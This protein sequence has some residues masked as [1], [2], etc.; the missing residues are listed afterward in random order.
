MSRGQ[1][2]V[3]PPY[4]RHNGFLVLGVEG[5]FDMD[6]SVVALL[7][8]ILVFATCLGVLFFPARF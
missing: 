6:I 1:G 4:F 5:R 8:L 2:E 7:E 3:V